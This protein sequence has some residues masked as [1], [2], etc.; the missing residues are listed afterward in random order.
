MKKPQQNIQHKIPQTSGTHLQGFASL[1]GTFAEN[2]IAH[3]P[4]IHWPHMSAINPHK[5]NKTNNITIM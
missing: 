4:L 3:P 2:L 1:C 5:L